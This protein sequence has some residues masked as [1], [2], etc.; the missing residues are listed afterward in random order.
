MGRREAGDV[1]EATGGSF[2][3]PGVSAAEPPPAK[4]CSKGFGSKERWD[5]AAWFAAK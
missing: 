1:I 4:E 2:V 5:V 3:P